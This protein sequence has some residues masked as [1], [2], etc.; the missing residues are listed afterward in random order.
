MLGR[1]LTPAATAGTVIAETATAGT[2]TMVVGTATGSVAETEAAGSVAKTTGSVAE[3]T[4]SVAKDTGRVAKNTA[5]GRVARTAARMAA[6]CPPRV[7]TSRRASPAI[8]TTW[9]RVVSVV[10]VVGETSL[11]LTTQRAGPLVLDAT[12]RVVAGEMQ[13]SKHPAML[14]GRTAPR[15]SALPVHMQTGHSHLLAQVAMPQAVMRLLLLPMQQ[16]LLQ[17]RLRPAAPPAVVLLPAPAQA[18]TAA[19][20][21]RTGLVA[22]AAVAVGTRGTLGTLGTLAMAVAATLA[23]LAT[24]VAAAA[25]AAASAA[26]VA[27]VGVV[28]LVATVCRALLVVAAMAAEQPSDIRSGHHPRPA[29]NDRR[30]P[31]RLPGLPLRLPLPVPLPLPVLL[32]LPVPVQVQPVPCLQPRRLYPSQRRATQHGGQA[33]GGMPSRRGHHHLRGDR[34]DVGL[35]LLRSRSHSNHGWCQVHGMG[36]G[37]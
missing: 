31:H 20:A 3:T 33:A 30:L 11:A 26:A 7:P 10:S 12:R 21:L 6:T 8:V 18:L 37:M 23:T 15:L 27:V 34:M 32:P 35:P 2:A 1:R 36:M 16:V 5:L 29:A 28:V 13:G 14:A 4:G 19:A 22:Q 9:V 17:P 25:S 24:P